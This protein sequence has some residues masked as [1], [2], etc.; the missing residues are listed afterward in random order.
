[1]KAEII[2]VGTELLLGEIINTNGQY[3]A[4]RLA[5][6]GIFV[7][8][9]TVVGDNPSRLRETYVQGFQR[10][11]LLI[12]TGGLGPTQDDLTKEMAAEYFQKKL[13]L[14]ISSLER[15]SDYFKGRGLPLTE[16][17][18]KQALFPEGSQILP[19]D[20]GTAPGCI[21][22][23][24]GKILIL[25][26][27]PPSEMIPMFEHYVVP[28]LQGFQEGILISKILHITG[29]GESHVEDQLQ[30]LIKKQ[31]NPTIA[32]YAK[33]GEVRLRITAR[34]STEQEGLLLIQPVEKEIRKRLGIHI[35][36]TD[37]TTLEQEIVRL[38]LE[39]NKTLSIAESCTG[40]M[41]CSRLVNYPGVSE[42][43]LEG[44]V[45]YSNEAKMSRLG[46]AKETLK[47]YGAVSEETAQ[48]MAIGIGRTAQTDIGLSVT[49]IAGPG[50][51]S[52]EKPVGLVYVGIFYNGKV[53]V[54]KLQFSGK[55]Q[56]I[57]ERVTVEALD[58]LR[59]KLLQMEVDEK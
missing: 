39:K 42:V 38:L 48:E 33:Q 26:P 52:K 36:G 37:E 20:H 14:D 27:G 23:K 9:Q 40:G 1:M 35:Y 56:K 24:E 55:R 19:N 41:I 18:K 7:Y 59:Q 4:K 44:A 50:G 51:G 10:A 54:K 30:D 8:Y 57:R 29:L 34:S 21:L 2:A 32:P 53:E 49:G 6:L 17:N 11:D 43:L 12:T 46:V 58:W 25:L 45:T 31:T 13:I 3:I 28:Y 22:E 15:I 47:Q 5:E 16:G